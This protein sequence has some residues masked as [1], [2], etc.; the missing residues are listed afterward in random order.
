[1]KKIFTLSFSMTLLCAMTFGQL[2]IT[3]GFETSEG[4]AT[5]FLVKNQNDWKDV[6]ASTMWKD[7]FSNATADNKSYK[8]KITAQKRPGS[9]GVQCMKFEINKEAFIPQKEGKTP[10]VKLRSNTLSQINPGENYALRL[11]AKTTNKNN[12][13]GKAGISG[14]NNDFQPLTDTWKEYVLPFVG[15]NT[16]LA[17]LF[18]DSKE[19]NCEVLVDDITIEKHTPTA[20][21]DLDAT[22]QFNLYPNPATSQLYLQ[23]EGNIEAVEIYSIS[24]QKVLDGTNISEGLDISQLLKG[25]YIVSA[26]VNGKPVQQKFTKK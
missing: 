12:E 20:I 26:T 3:N 9:T 18:F 25:M 14:I 1:M 17:Q 16:Q 7:I 6:N 8:S 10:T 5:D 4:F 2:P 19:Q 15:L 24:G 13:A 11:W 21:N 22:D 23:S